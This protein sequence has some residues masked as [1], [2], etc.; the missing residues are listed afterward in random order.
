MKGVPGGGR[1]SWNP[2]TPDNPNLGKGVL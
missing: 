1:C 2:D